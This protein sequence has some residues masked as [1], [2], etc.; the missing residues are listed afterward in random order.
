MS[1]LGSENTMMYARMNVMRAEGSDSRDGTEGK[2]PRRFLHLPPI[3]L[4]AT[5]VVLKYTNLCR[6][7][8][9]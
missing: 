5:R 9:P 3:R 6:V 8:H 2:V 7:H 1:L 4:L